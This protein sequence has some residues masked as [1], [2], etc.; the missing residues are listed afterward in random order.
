MCI[1]PFYENDEVGLTGHFETGRNQEN[2]DTFG[3]MAI[4][5]DTE[6]RPVASEQY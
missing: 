6:E 1:V 5:I 2:V 3:G 4:Q